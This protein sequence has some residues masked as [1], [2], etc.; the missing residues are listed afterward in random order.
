MRSDIVPGGTRP[1]VG[2]FA[3]DEFADAIAAAVIEAL[4]R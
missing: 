1:T 3:L 2:R 4:S